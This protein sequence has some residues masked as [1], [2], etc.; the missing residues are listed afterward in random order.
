M[1]F[2][3]AVELLAVSQQEQK[4]IAQVM[5]EREVSLF[6]KTEDDVMAAMNHAMIS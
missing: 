6:E 1:D 5:V 3:N 2:K 4:T